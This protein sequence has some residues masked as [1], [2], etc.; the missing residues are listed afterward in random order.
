MDLERKNVMFTQLIEMGFKE[1][2]VGFP[3]PP[4]PISTSYGTSSKT[5]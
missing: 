5:T 4:S 3:S 1:I 2:E